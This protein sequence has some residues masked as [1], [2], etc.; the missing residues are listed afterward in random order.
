FFTS[1]NVLSL[2]EN[3]KVLDGYALYQ[4]YPNPFNPATHIRYQLPEADY[5]KLVVYDMLGR[6]LKTLVDDFRE[7]GY[8]TVI[9]DGTNQFGKT[10]SSGVYLYRLTA[11]SGREEKFNDINKMV[12]MR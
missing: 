5:V 9:W 8:Y 7:E 10:A 3:E 12:L 4:N 6:E 11:T 2:K 1:D